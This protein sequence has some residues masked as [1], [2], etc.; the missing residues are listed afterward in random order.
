MKARD[1]IENYLIELGISLKNNYTFIPKRDYQYSKKGS[2]ETVRLGTY[3]V[4]LSKRNSNTR[5]LNVILNYTRDV[6]IYDVRLSNNIG[7]A[8]DELASSAVCYYAEFIKYIAYNFDISVDIA[9][10]LIALVEGAINNTEREIGKVVSNYNITMDKIKD[11]IASGRAEM[12]AQAVA[13]GTKVRGVHT[14]VTHHD[15]IFGDSYYVQAT[16]I[17]MGKER[18]NAMISGANNA[19]DNLQSI[20]EKGASDNAVESLSGI[21]AKI[22]NYFNDK[23]KD[24][25][26]VKFDDFFDEDLINDRGKNV[27]DNP[28]MY[29]HYLDVVDSLSEEQFDDFKKAIEY[30]N[31]S[32]VDELKEKVVNNIYNYFIN[33]SKCDYDKVDYKLYTYLTGDKFGTGSD[34]SKKIKC[35]LTN[36]KFGDP[37]DNKIVIASF[38]KKRE[39]VNKC[40]YLTSSEKDEILK[41][42]DKFIADNKKTI[43]NNIINLI[44]SIIMV[45][46]GIYAAFIAGK[47]AILFGLYDRGK[48]LL[49]FCGIIVTAFVSFGILCMDKKW[50]K[51]VLQ[52]ILS[53]AFIMIPVMWSKPITD[54]AAMREGKH[55]IEIRIL[56]E[57]EIIFLEEGAQVPLEKLERSGYVFNGW[58]HNGYYINMPVKVTEKAIY[59]ADLE[60]SSEDMTT[61]TYKFK[62][63]QSNLV[64]KVKNGVTANLPKPPTRKGYK[65]DGWYDDST[66]ERFDGRNTYNAKKISVSAKWVKE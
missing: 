20:Y 51:K 37:K 25:L 17:T 8:C 63:G 11:K 59:I 13:E 10:K 50:Y 3:K 22:L 33:T 31:M 26:F 61:I 5:E 7:R 66:K 40:D 60:E 18:T 44:L 15:G 21:K 45:V 36:I 35:Y 47:Y 58:V 38:D 49:I 39:L 2:S 52:V 16:P 28:I 4:E 32:I 43:T 12:T 41:S 19:A 27:S 54:E 34:V 14:T 1:V 62:N 55:K 48:K 64:I 9:E 65:F 30:Y 24:L 42:Y 53:I 56:D 29:G 57:K 6:F 23:L 46:L